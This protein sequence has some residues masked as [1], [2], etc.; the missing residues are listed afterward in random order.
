MHRPSEVAYSC[1]KLPLR[2]SDP[3]LPSCFEDF[4]FLSA[5]VAI[6]PCNRDRKRAH[7][8]GNSPLSRGGLVDNIRSYSIRTHRVYYS[9]PVGKDCS[10]VSRCSFL[11]FVLCRETECGVIL[12]ACYW[13]R[14]LDWCLVSAR[15]TSLLNTARSSPS[16]PASKRNLD[17]L[18]KHL[19]PS[20]VA[21]L[22]SLKLVAYCRDGGFQN[23]ADCF[24]SS[25]T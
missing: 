7:G 13:S 5:A 3:S 12:C 10:G 19:L 14:W 25:S 1:T 6:S 8:V 24:S 4:S 9:T 20:L 16:V 2:L 18:L 11:W 21:E 22:Q 15:P 23:T 17:R